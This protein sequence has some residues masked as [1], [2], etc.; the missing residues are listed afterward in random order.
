MTLVCF[1]DYPM[2]FSHA[3]NC[4][5]NKWIYVK[6]NRKRIEYTC[7][8]EYNEIGF[9]NPV[10]YIEAANRRFVFEKKKILNQVQD[11]KIQYPMILNSFS[12]SMRR[13]FVI[14]PIK[15]QFSPNKA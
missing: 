11:V 14:I 8:I 3:N 13:I 12:S 1:T 15:A 4:I 6:N 5:Y 9:T 10:S 2:F 7:H